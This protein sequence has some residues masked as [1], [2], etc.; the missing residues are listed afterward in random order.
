MSFKRMRNLAGMLCTRSPSFR[1]IL[2]TLMAL[3]FGSSAGWLQAQSIPAERP[4]ARPPSELSGWAEW[5]RAAEIF[6]RIPVP[7]SPA[8]S[9]EEAQKTFRVAPGFRLELVAAEPMV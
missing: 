1:G 2:R 6:S 9:P 5:E 8:L 7:P 4:R 3:L